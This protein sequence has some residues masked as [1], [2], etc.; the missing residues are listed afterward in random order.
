MSRSTNTETIDL[1]ASAGITELAV[2]NTDVAYSY[3]FLT[4]K[5]AYG[6]EIQLD[7]SSGTADVKIEMESGG[8]EPDTEGTADT[9]YTVPQTNEA[10]IDSSC[11]TE[12]VRF[13]PF[14]PVVAPFCR[15]KFTGQ[16]A[17]PASCKVARARIHMI[18]G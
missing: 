10:V 7:V 14:P 8:T 12:L 18:Q 15:L 9:D 1:L 13:Y 3:S 11:N 2:A 5:R 4:D 6:L 17:N 16:G